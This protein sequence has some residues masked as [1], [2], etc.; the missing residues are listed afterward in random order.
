M[1][2]DVIGTLLK[3]YGLAVGTLFGVI[4]AIMKGYLVP[5]VVHDQYKADAE[6]K[7]AD[8]R[9]DYDSKSQ[10]LNELR[11][12]MDAERVQFMSPLVEMFKNIKKAENID[13]RGG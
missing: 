12:N 7:Y 2:W 8:L 13:D 4:F 3:D 11:R 10:E 9:A 1:G 5:G 6:K